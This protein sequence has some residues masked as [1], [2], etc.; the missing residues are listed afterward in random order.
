MKFKRIF[1]AVALFAAKSY[2]FKKFSYIDFKA[3]IPIEQNSRANFLRI[4]YVTITDVEQFFH[5]RR[6]SKN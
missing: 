3:T 4:Q 5:L 2:V 1:Y 6:T